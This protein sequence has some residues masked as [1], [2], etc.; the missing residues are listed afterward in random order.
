MDTQINCDLMRFELGKLSLGLNFQPIKIAEPV[1]CSKKS[2]I[3]IFFHPEK[4]LLATTSNIA[5]L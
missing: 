5:F 2:L 4:D 3:G 1:F